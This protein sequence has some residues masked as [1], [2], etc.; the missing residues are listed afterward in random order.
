MIAMVLKIVFIPKYLYRFAKLRIKQLDIRK[1]ARRGFGR[2]L[3]FA[4][5]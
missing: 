2:L 3:K 4:P 1:A 5:I